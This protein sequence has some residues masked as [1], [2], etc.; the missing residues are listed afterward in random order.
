MMY[1]LKALGKAVLA[2]AGIGCGVCDVILGVPVA[3]NYLNEVFKGKK[4]EADATNDEQS[5]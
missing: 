2:L 4:K 5:N 3:M 1:R